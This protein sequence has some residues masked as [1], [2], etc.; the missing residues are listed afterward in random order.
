M[1]M[2]FLVSVMLGVG[3]CAPGMHGGFH[4]TDAQDAAGQPQAAS[5]DKVNIQ[6]DQSAWINNDHARAFYAL[7]VERLGK[8][9]P[10]LDFADYRDMSYAIFR[11]LGTSMGWSAEAMVDHLKLIPQQMVDI[12][13]EDPK[14]LD[15]YDSFT[16]ALMGP[17]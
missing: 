7:S 15:S 4:H 11:E 12:V 17:Q 10:K 2:I 5:T 13:R 8:T 3:G 6:G 14:V 1:R 16:V 9:A